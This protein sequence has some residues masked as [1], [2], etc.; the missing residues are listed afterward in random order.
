MD[1]SDERAYWCA[2]CNEAMRISDDEVPVEMIAAQSGG[3][4]VRIVTVAGVE[5]HRCVL[6]DSPGAM[7][8]NG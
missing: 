5:V 4:N 8:V 3:P 1:R 2:A 6:V 7:R